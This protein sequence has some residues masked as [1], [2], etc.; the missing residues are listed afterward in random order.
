MISE[1]T[2]VLTNGSQNKELEA[3][4]ERK[5][6][7]KQLEMQRKELSRSNRASMPKAPSYSTYT[8]P[9]RAP[10]QSTYDSYEAEKNRTYKFVVQ[11]SL[12]FML[13]LRQ[14]TNF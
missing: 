7:A 10:S 13:T 6:K 2:L 9:P 5:R 11:L 1:V 14:A 3:T 4:E 12:F 8:P